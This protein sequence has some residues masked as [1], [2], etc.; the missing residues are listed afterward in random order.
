MTL[1]GIREGRE[2]VR[3]ALTRIQRS[4]DEWGVQE[5]ERLIRLTHESYSHMGYMCDEERLAFGW[6]TDPAKLAEML[7]ER[8]RELG[9]VAI[10][11]PHDSEPENHT[12]EDWWLFNAGGACIRAFY[13][14]DYGSGIDGTG[15]AYDWRELAMPQARTILLQWLQLPDGATCD[16]CKGKTNA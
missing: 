13:H 9:L 10:S 8:G 12:N 4:V 6:L 11:G 15:S 5:T 2:W 16:N 14:Y 3:I 1:I 7:A